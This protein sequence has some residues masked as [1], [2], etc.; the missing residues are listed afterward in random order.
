MQVVIGSYFVV[1][2]AATGLL[3]PSRMSVIG[4]LLMSWGLLKHGI[5][6]PP[7][8]TEGAPPQLLATLLLLCILA[9]GASAKPQPRPTPASTTEDKKSN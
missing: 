2:G 5:F 9:Y 1:A 3:Q 7:E 6:K 8:S 4:T